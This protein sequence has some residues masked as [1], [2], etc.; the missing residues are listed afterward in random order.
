MAGGVLFGSDVW[1]PA[2][3]VAQIVA[4]Q[5]LFYLSLSVLTYVIVGEWGQSQGCGRGGRPPLSRGGQPLL[6]ARR[7]RALCR[8]ADALP[9]V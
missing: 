1:D 6:R 8:H 9:A 3:I 5:C 7:R 2:R 4:V